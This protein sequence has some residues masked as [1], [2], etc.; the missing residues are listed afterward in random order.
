MF[1]RDASINRVILGPEVIL[2]LLPLLEVAGQ[3][4]I[5]MQTVIGLPPTFAAAPP[6][7]TFSSSTST[8]A[9]DASTSTQADDEGTV[10]SSSSKPAKIPRPPNAFI[11]YRK[12]YHATIVGQNPG[13]HN[14]QICKCIP[15]LRVSFI[16]DAIQP[17]SSVPCGTV[18]LR[19]LGP[20]SRLRQ[21]S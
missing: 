20:T 15:S 12:A 13:L 5:L 14:N 18:S 17:S 4:P 16:S 6:P 11:L 8:Q 2:Q 19:K 9:D 1:A 21:R 10:V 7:G 3:I